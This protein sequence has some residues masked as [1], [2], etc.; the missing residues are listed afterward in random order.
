MRLHFERFF[1]VLKVDRRLFEHANVPTGSKLN[2]VTVFERLICVIY[3]YVSRSTKHFTSAGT[4]S[5]TGVISQMASCHTVQP[6][7]LSGGSMERLWGASTHESYKGI[8]RVYLT[9]CVSGFTL[10]SFSDGWICSQYAPCPASSISLQDVVLSPRLG[11]VVLIWSICV[12]IDKY[13]CKHR[14]GI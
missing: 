14:F 2:A 8:R 1:V 3:A 7:H 4:S 5:C 10:E 13:F 11:L 12:Y 6:A 9:N